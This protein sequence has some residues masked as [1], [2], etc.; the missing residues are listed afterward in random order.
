MKCVDGQ[1][2]ELARGLVAYG[3]RDLERII[4]QPTDQIAP[5]LGFTNGAE[6]IHRDDLAVLAD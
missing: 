2:R 6:V 1:G 3:S 4:G 5:V